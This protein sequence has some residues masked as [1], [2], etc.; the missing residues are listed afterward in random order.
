MKANSNSKLLSIF[1]CA[2]TALLVSACSTVHEK[3]LATSSTVMRLLG[4][5]VCSHDGTNW[6]MLKVGDL[7]DA[8]SYVRT[9]DHGELIISLG[10]QIKVARTSVLDG[11]IYDPTI[12]PAN[13]LALFPDSIVKLKSVR[14]RTQPD[15]MN[16][17]ENI[18]A[19]Y[20]GTIQG[21]VMKTSTCQIQITN[22]LVKMEEGTYRMDAAGNISQFYGRGNIALPESNF[23]NKL[24]AGQR[25]EAETLTTS[26]FPIYPLANWPHD[27][28]LPHDPAYVPWQNDLEPWAQA[29]DRVRRSAPPLPQRPF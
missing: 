13:L 11:S 14:P 25:F 15:P 21:C 9:S 10:E 4:G 22:G 26:N 12:H 17:D 20:A 24:S 7:I 29:G 1:C 27:L 23:T 8:D 6:N 2:L 18:V 19:L 5:A 16:G 3:Q 28:W